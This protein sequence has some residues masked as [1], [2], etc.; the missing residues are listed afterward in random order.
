MP[1]EDDELL[2]GPDDPRWC[3]TPEQ[4]QRVAALYGTAFLRQKPS[5]IS[6]EEYAARIDNKDPTMTEKP[7]DPTKPHRQRNGL[8]A[9]AWPGPSGYLFGW[10]KINENHAGEES[11][12]WQSDGCWLMS[13]CESPHDL[14]NIPEKIVRWVNVYGSSPGMFY[15]HFT[16]E[17]ARR[18]GGSDR[19]ACLRI[20]FEPG[21]GLTD[22]ERKT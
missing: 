18:N 8:P 2:I 7:F 14:V 6:L 16:R 12:S 10:M 20:E 5:R 4:V 22:E 21:E 15:V 9:Q 13:K 19:I 1:E 17:E 11:A 3:D